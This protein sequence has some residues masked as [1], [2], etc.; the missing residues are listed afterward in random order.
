MKIYGAKATINIKYMGGIQGLADLLKSGLMIPEL[1]VS[2]R[3]THPYDVMG[4]A[5]ALGF[6][7][8]LEQNQPGQPY[9]YRL[10]IE[11]S[12]SLEESFSDQMHDLSPWLARYISTSCDVETSIAGISMRMPKREP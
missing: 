11:T 6:E 5:E 8:W 2:P 3:E 7:L 1:N 10:T 12:H 4:S 9:Q